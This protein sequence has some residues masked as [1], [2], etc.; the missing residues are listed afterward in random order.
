MILLFNFCSCF[1]YFIPEEDFVGLNFIDDFVV[2]LVAV[3]VVV[4]V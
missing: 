2:F 4:V 3:V 1:I